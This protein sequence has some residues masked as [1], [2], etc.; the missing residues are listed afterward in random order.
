MEAHIQTIMSWM[1]NFAA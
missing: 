1:C